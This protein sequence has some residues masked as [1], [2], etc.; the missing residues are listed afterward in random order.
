ML[1]KFCGL[2]AAKNVVFVTTKWNPNAE[3]LGIERERQLSE[4]LSH[5]RNY[6]MRMVRFWPRDQAAAWKIIDCLLEQPLIDAI[7]IQRD[8][9]DRRLPLAQTEAAIFLE[10]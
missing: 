6:G 10:V 7:Q 4:K 1:E 9:V 2:E 5:M 3:S 8:I